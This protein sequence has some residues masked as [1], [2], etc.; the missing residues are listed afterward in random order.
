M[1][2]EEKVIRARMA[3]LSEAGKDIGSELSALVLKIEDLTGDTR[4]AS[5]DADLIDVMLQAITDSA[6]MKKLLR[7]NYHETDVF[8]SAARTVFAVDLKDAERDLRFAEEAYMNRHWYD[9]IEALKADD[10]ATAGAA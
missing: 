5:E 8:V 3:K 10:R 6:H 7:D 9:Q 2:I 4:P 1:R